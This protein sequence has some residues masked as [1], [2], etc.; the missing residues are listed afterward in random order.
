[1]VEIRINLPEHF[2]EEEMRD[3]YLVSYEMKQVW[4]VELDLLEQF[5]RV[6]DKYSLSWYADGGTMLG[7]VRHNGFIPWDNDIDVSMPRK[8]YDILCSVAEYEFCAPYFFQTARSDKYY[9]RLHAQLRNSSTTGILNSERPKHLKFNQGIFIDI[10]PFDNI[11]DDSVKL[12]SFTKQLIGLS[13]DIFYYKAFTVEF[14]RSKN[15]NF[16]KRIKHLTKFVLI[17]SLLGGSK[18]L[19]KI[20]S[21][22]ETH[23]KKYYGINTKRF[24]NLSVPYYTVEKSNYFM[25]EWYEKRDY[26]PFE[27]VELPVPSGYKDYLNVVYGN[28]HKFVISES[29]HGDVF[30]DVDK[31]YLYYL[32]HD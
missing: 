23:C 32:N 24:A 8:D 13:D 29:L 7:A 21:E 3:G 20:F 30:F 19:D 22:T 28:W 26:L 18:K 9:Y 12:D 2:L 17:N 10:F 16:F 6:C 15:P 5:R 27:F 25:K 14:E 11:P 31:P 1:M 4:A